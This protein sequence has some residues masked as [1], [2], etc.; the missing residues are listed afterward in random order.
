MTSNLSMARQ[1]GENVG[2]E[3]AFGSGVKGR[4][5]SR[6]GREGDEGEDGT[7]LA[8]QTPKEA[9]IARPGKGSP[10]LS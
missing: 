3:A 5:E 1:V 4:K 8:Q 9:F 10:M 7:R 6:V 2:R